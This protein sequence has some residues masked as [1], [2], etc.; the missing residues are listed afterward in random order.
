MDLLPF[1]RSTALWHRGAFLQQRLQHLLEVVPDSSLSADEV[2]DVVVQL[3]AL[4]AR[5]RATQ[6]RLAAGERL[7]P[8]TSIDKVLLATTDQAVFDLVEHALPEDVLSGDDDSGAR[9]RAE[10]LYSR[11]ATIYGGSAEIQ[12]NV[13]ARRVLDLGPES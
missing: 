12:R 11:A 10:Y 5:S 1:E 3:F 4:R 13:L 6:H 2:G 7:G 8:E 9:W